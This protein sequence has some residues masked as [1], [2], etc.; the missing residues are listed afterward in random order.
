[1]SQQEEIYNPQSVSEETEQ[2]QVD[3]TIGGWLAFFLTMSVG[4]G[5]I[6]TL[7]FNIAQFDTNI[8]KISPLLGSADIAIAIAY[9][10]TGGFTIYA[11][12]RGDG[13]AVFLAKTFVVISFATGI[14]S[15]ILDDGTETADFGGLWGSKAV[16]R[17]TVM[18]VVWFLYLTFSKRVNAVIPKEI[19]KI[20]RRDW[21]II[22]V[23]ILVPVVFIG[24]GM[25]QL[26]YTSA[27]ETDIIKSLQLAPNQYTDGRIIVSIPE[28]FTCNIDADDDISMF[29]IE[30]FNTGNLIKITS[31]Y[32]T[33]STATNFEKTYWRAFKEGLLAN[34]VNRIR[35]TKTQQNL[36]HG[37][38]T[39]TKE[40]ILPDVD[41]TY[42]MEF[43][44][45]F[46]KNTGKGVTILT[47]YYVDN[48]PTL[49]DILSCIQFIP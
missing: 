5:S 31:T 33:N 47:N 40:V 30:D 18:S 41:L 8:Y 21:W 49:Q 39:F 46:D 1:M 45:A 25:F 26:F 23:N 28:N 22:A 9:A 7:I 34:G 3:A 16:I 27:K 35:E 24:V 11:F 10:M 17:S 44:A 2:E 29:V 6:I 36:I 20:K 15:L 48:Y 12:H 13:D 14:L 42:S 37:Y 38:T 4:L 43:T 32:D 19:R